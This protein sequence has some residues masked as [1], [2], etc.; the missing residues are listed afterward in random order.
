MRTH[1]TRS[2]F[3]AQ[4]RGDSVGRAVVSN[5]AVNTFLRAAIYDDGHSFLRKCGCDSKT[6]AGGRS[7]HKS[8][9]RRVED[10]NYI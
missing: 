5:R 6:N 3:G 4:I 8:V 1:S 7:S 10:H 9:C 2:S